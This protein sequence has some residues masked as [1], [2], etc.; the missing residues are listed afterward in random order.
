MNRTNLKVKELEIIKNSEEDKEEVQ[1]PNECRDDEDEYG[2]HS[3]EMD[4]KV[5]SITFSSSYICI[6]FCLNTTQYLD[7][8]IEKRS[9]GEN[10]VKRRSCLS[11]SKD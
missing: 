6:L 11:S 5:R 10:K 8:K 2:Q 4:R 1:D 3:N 7:Y 9:R